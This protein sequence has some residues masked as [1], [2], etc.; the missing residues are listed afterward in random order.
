MMDWIRENATVLIEFFLI[1]IW[2]IIV[3]YT[4]VTHGDTDFAFV[5]LYFCYAI[6]KFMAINSNIEKR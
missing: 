6:E 2:G 4:V 3:A 1:V 5:I